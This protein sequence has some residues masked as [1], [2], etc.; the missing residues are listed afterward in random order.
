MCASSKPH[1]FVNERHNIFCGSTY[2][3]CRDHI[4]EGKDLPQQLGQKENNE[5]GKT[6]SLMLMVCR[7]IFG[8]GKDYVL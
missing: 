8:S 6:V 4:V 5:L 2:I 7:S 1:P 3:L